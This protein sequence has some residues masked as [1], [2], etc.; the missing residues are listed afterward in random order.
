MRR[1]LTEAVRRTRSF[2]PAIEA[3]A[4]KQRKPSVAAVFEETSSYNLVG[5]YLLLHRC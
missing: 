3:G 4:L 2:A 1:V 5:A